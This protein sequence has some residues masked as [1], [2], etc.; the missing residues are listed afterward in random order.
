[1]N[2][3]LIYSKSFEGHSKTFEG[4]STYPNAFDRLRQHGLKLQLKKCQFLQA[5]TNYL[6]FVINREEIK[7][8]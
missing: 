6:G 1:M 7:P 4:P 3:I 8:C 5:E 2:D